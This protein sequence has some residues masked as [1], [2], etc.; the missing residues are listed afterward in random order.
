[1]KLQMKYR[2]LANQQIMVFCKLKFNKNRVY[3]S[4][5]KLEQIAAEQQQ[6]KEFIDIIT[7][8]ESGELPFEIGQSYDVRNGV[9]YRIVERNDETLFLP[10]V[11]RSL[12]WSIIG[13]IHSKI[14]HLGYIQT[15]HSLYGLYYAPGMR[16]A[17]KKFIENC[18]VC[19]SKK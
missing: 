14:H 15:L 7:K 10:V 5:S 13:H 1:M 8:W 6:D 3:V 9:L 4:D 16:K 12:I 19:K 2:C 11:P 18:P 17:V